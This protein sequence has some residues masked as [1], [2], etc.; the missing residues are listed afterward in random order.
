MS[1]EIHYTLRY[2]DLP[3][4]AILKKLKPKNKYLGN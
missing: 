4:V 3:S 2:E 1:K